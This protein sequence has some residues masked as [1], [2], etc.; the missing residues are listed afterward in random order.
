MRRLAK[1]V[2]SNTGLFTA[3]DPETNVFL[4]VGLYSLRTA[5]ATQLFLNELQDKHDIEDAEFFVDGAPWLHAGLFVLG[6]HFRHETHGDRNPVERVFQEIKRRTGQFY[7]NFPTA[8]P[9]TVESWL[10]ALAWGQNEL[11]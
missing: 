5:V 6:M 10:R 8:E 9:E 3:V 2:V 1:L 7:N 11:N 4:H